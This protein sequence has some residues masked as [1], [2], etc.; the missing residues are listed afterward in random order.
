MFKL[1]K[2]LENDTL[3]IKELENL[4]VRLMINANEFFNG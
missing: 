1:D 3:L 2:R 4:Q